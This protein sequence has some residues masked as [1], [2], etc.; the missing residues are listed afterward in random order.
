MDAD[1]ARFALEAFARLVSLTRTS[2]KNPE[3]VALRG[4]EACPS[5]P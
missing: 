2:Q 3:G 4:D 1:D 5:P